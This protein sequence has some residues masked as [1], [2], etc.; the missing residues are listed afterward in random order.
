M[1]VHYSEIRNLAQQR[2][3]KILEFGLGDEWGPLCEFLEV[4]VLI[5]RI[6]ERTREVIGY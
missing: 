4:D 2:E 1:R 6:Q 3:A 5:I